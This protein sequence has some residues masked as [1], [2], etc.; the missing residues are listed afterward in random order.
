VFATNVLIAAMLASEKNFE[1]SKSSEDSLPLISD[2]LV[3]L[4]SIDWT[5]LSSGWM[6][7]LLVFFLQ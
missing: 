3:D 5:D 6:M 4:L 1:L 2:S 7:P